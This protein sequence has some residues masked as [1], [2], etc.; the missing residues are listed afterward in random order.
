MTL[1]DIELLLNQEGFRKANKVITDATY[2]RPTSGY[3]LGKF[4]EFYRAWL[5]EHSLGVWKEKY[6]CDNFASTFY[7]FAQICH[8]KSNR[9]EQGI[10]VGELYYRQDTGGGHVINM[11]VTERG[12]ILIEPQTGK[13]VEITDNEKSN[14]VLIHF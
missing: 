9:P 8:F 12:L 7:T 1:A 6:D 14:T 3:M 5:T 4:Y 11:S 2:A 10:A 13:E